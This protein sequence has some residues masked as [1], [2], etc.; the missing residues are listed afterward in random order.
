MSESREHKTAMALIKAGDRIR[1]LKAKGADTESIQQEQRKVMRDAANFVVELIGKDCLWTFEGNQAPASFVAAYLRVLNPL[2]TPVNPADLFWKTVIDEM[3]RLE[4]GDEPDIFKP[5]ARQP[6]QNPRPA[7]LAIGRLRALEWAVYMKGSGL[8]PAS[9]QKLI[10]LAF[11][12]DWDAIRHWRRSIC[13]VLGKET[14]EHAL[15]FASQGYFIERRDWH[16][17]Y[18]DALW[19]DGLFYRV[20]VG[21]DKMSKADSGEWDILTASLSL[22]SVAGLAE[23][24]EAEMS[25]EDISE[26][27]DN[28][29]ASLSL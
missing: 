14:T 19:I 29:A 27:W 23:M 17:S 24:S 4:F 20:V 22:R 6:G 5:A 8:R 2:F 7:E 21:L 12:A 18:A 26:K 15:M 10:A 9:F 3:D 25:E 11:G 1:R 13:K 16:M 28:L